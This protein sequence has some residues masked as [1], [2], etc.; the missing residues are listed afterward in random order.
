MPFQTSPQ[1]AVP[2]TAARE[3]NTEPI[4]LSLEAM[5]VEF[6]PLPKFDKKLL[7]GY[8]FNEK[9]ILRLFIARTATESPLL[10]DLA[11]FGFDLEDFRRFLSVYSGRTLRIPKKKVWA[12][13]WFDLHL[14]LAVENRLVLFPKEDFP[15]PYRFVA[16]KYNVSAAYVQSVHTKFA[17][18]HDIITK[19]K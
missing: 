14:W 19:K 8:K 3:Q 7:H 2:A 12:K 4:Y 6:A 11:E 16:R 10:S 18:T 5:A 15:L 13:V 17:S 1:R 9:A